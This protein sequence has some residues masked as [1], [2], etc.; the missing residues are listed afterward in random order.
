MNK[1]LIKKLLELLT[2]WV[3]YNVI[4]ALT[5]FIW[6]LMYTGN[7]NQISVRINDAIIML[8]NFLELTAA[9]FG[10]FVASYFI[11]QTRI[12]KE[13]IKT[14][15]L[16]IIFHILMMGSFLISLYLIKKINPWLAPIE[17]QFV[18]VVSTILVAVIPYFKRRIF[19]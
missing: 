11:I 15:S 10:I 13:D 14:I 9:G 18:F 17:L 6:D 2:G 12:F 5:Y 1:K 4:L 7:Y 19:E 16:I 3:A 8:G